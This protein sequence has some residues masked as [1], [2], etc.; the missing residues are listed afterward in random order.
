MWFKNKTKEFWTLKVV[1]YLNL[2]VGS[3]HHG[4]SVGNSRGALAAASGAHAEQDG[5]EDVSLQGVQVFPV[6]QREGRE[7]A[8]EE[9]RAAVAKDAGK[10]DC[11]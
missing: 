3:S 10:K 6:I 9:G 5:E 11:R 8:H 1:R 7:L 4:V 2:E